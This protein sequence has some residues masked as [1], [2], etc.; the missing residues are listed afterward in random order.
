MILDTSAAVPLLLDHELSDVARRTLFG[1][2]LVSPALIGVET[3]NA[4]WKYAV[5]DGLTTLQLAEMVSSLNEIVEFVPDTQLLSHAIE[6]AVEH[7]HPVYNC[8]YLALALQRRE[9][10]ATA[11]RRLAALARQLSIGTE[12][13]EP[14]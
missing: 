4:L 14:A 2:P 12:L 3:A 5:R 13:I 8:L 6:L 9:P 11:D 1:Q 10:L 7:R